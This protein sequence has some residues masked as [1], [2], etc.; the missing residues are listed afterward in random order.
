MRRYH[1]VRVG[2][3]LIWALDAALKWQPG[4]RDT[5]PS[6]I[7]DAAQGQPRWLAGWFSF[8][9]QSIAH[10]PTLFAVLLALAETAI[11][12]SLILGIAQRVGFTGG[13]VLALLIWAIGEGFG[14]PYA[15]GGSDIG[16]A[17][18]YAVLF[19]GLWL[20]VPRTVR[21]AAP[22]L[23]HKL[24]PHRAWRWATFAPASP[25]TLEG[26]FQ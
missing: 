2:F 24:A 18:M 8:W 15:S 1:W 11:A 7:T 14:G 25:Y 4:F 26:T 9:D 23:D 16:A 21:I 3:G 22:A 6:M 12:L 10:A 20:A 5:Y 19:G 17:I 13:I